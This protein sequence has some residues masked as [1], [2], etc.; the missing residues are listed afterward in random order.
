MKKIL[1]ILS[2]ALALTGCA[3]QK[4]ADLPRLPPA[5]AISSFQQLGYGE[6]VKNPYIRTE[7]ICG[8]KKVN[9]EF[10][11]IQVASFSLRQSQLMFTSTKEG[12]CG[13]NYVFALK[14]LDDARRLVS[15]AVSLG[16]KVEYFFA[17]D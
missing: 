7:A 8:A 4:V 12:I 16:A 9:I 5:E 14:D 3:M 6:W 1:L 2:A 13:G 17:K 11:D 15:A 10:S